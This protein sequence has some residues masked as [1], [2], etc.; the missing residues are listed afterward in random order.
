[1]AF[2]GLVKGQDT[3]RFRSGEVKAVKV[4]EVGLNEIK[5]NRFDN[6]TGPTYVSPKSDV[7]LIRYAGGQVDSFKVA[8]QQPLKEQEPK[9]SNNQG[10]NS[11]IRSNEKI[12]IRGT[13]LFYQGRPMGEARL[14]KLVTEFPD[15]NKRIDLF[16]EFEVLRAYKKKQSLYFFG[17]LGAGV[18]LAY[19][20][21]II[22]A[23]TEDAT[24]LL[25]TLP[26]GVGLGV[27]GTVLSAKQKKKKLMQR[28]KV[29][30]L[31]NDLTP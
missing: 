15:Q 30:Q 13:D 4:N 1:M 22:T 16:K 26:I 7:M 18:G 17:G 21:F 11:G 6:L 8:V 24:P 14:K 19:I 2:A 3:I 31:Y 27:T 9:A 28:A 23:I 29:A 20:G 10:S 25:V 12:V 5:Y